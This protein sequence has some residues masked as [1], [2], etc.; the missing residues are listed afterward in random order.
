MLTVIYTI[1][2]S[3]VG[4]VAPT[5]LALLPPNVE[6]P[7]GGYVWYE[8]QIVDWVQGPTPTAF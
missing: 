2:N 7:K 4:A 3:F 8:K 1:Y 6:N 5:W